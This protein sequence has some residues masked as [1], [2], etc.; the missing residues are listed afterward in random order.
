MNEWVRLATHR[1]VVRR[2]LRYAIGVG[3]LLIV[4]NHGDA[5]LRRD[6]SI[7]RLLRMALTVTVP[8]AVSTASSVSAMRERRRG[9]RVTMT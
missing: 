5:L 7:G 4:I 2:A 3:T 6:L 9:D 8:Y 1:S